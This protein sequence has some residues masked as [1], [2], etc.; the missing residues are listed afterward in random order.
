MKTTVNQ[1]MGFL[2]SDPD[3]KFLAQKAFISYIR[4]IFLQS[5]KEVFKVTEMDTAGLASSFGLPGVYTRM[6]TGTRLLIHAHT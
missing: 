2:A 5:N 1:L 6:Q 4:S 3:L